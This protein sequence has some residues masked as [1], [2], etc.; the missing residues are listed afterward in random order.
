MTEEEHRVVL[1]II[2]RQ[3]DMPSLY[4]GGASPGSL[5]RAQEIIDMLEANGVH[6]EIT[7]RFYDA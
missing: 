4:M 5:R 2:G 7:D 3:I 1:Q 6:L